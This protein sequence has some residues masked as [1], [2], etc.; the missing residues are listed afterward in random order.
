[1]M[2]LR[3]TAREI[4]LASLRRIDVATVMERKLRVEDGVLRVAG[5]AAYDLRAFGRV[6]VV[7]AG[8]AAAPMAETLVRLLRPHLHA[9]QRL[10]G[11]SVGTRVAD[12]PEIR[13]FLGGHPVPNEDS[14]RAAD[15]VLEYLS[16]RGEDGDETLVLFLISGGASALLERPL[17]G[18]M[19]LADTVAF[20]QVLVHSGLDIAAMNVLRKHFSAV[21]GGRLAVAAGGAAQCTVLISDVPGNALHVVGSGPTLADPSTV[22][23]CRALLE[24]HGGAL[25][26]P[27]RVVEL[28]VDGAPAETPK[29]GHPAFARASR[30]A[31]LSSDDLCVEAAE[32]ARQR[33][34]Q[35]VVDTTCDEWPCGEAAEYLLARVA[36]LSGS[37]A[38]VCLVSAGEISVAVGGV[39]GVGGR[40]QHFVL[41]CAR[42][43]AASGQKLTVLSGG[44]D[45]VDGNGDAA[46]GVADETTVA[47]AA[48]LGLSVERALAGFD[49]SSL[50]EALGDTLVTGPSGN[51]VRDLRL[52]L[53]D[54]ACGAG[55]RT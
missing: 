50:L 52:L 49:S 26:F 36:E 5:A 48:G 23:D 18:S 6:K 3:E 51:N 53:A 28:F 15:A 45:G 39:H 20:H 41:E 17:D 55:R 16:E 54:R 1:M 21:K 43:I 27:A 44:S 7:S 35:V 24:R 10:D 22:A 32:V 33:G 46:G 42:R 8:K 13:S 29:Y 37:H 47:R 12:D 25:P 14:W 11:I 19:T 4:F 34:F 31:L 30:M 9:W 40:N 2:P 38:R